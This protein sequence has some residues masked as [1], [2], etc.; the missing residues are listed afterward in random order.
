MYLDS[1]RKG[2]E[3]SKGNCGAFNSSKNE[4]KISALGS[5]KNFFEFGNCRKLK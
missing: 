2:Q 5:K 1:F 3:I 4:R